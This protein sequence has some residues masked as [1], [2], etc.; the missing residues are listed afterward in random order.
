M[1]REDSLVKG[2]PVG[3]LPVTESASS[4]DGGGELIYVTFL[5]VPRSTEMTRGLVRLG[6]F[7]SSY[8]YFKK[9]SYTGVPNRKRLNC[10][11]ISKITGYTA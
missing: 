8:F 11:L 9:D 10:F 1:V 4:V 3:A 2:I 5:D 7:Y 6:V